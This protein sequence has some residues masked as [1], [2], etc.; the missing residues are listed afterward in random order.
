MFLYSAILLSDLI[1]IPIL[2]LSRVRSLVERKNSK[3]ETGTDDNCI[4]TLHGDDSGDQ[5][6]RQT[7]MFKDV[8]M[9]LIELYDNADLA[10]HLTR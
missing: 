3:I 7:L 9:F 8:A 10:P 6:L 1:L 4:H 5:L 2:F